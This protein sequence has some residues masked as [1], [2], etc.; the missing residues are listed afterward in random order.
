MKKARGFFKL[1]KLYEAMISAPA[2]RR[3][4]KKPARLAVECLEARETPTT[5]TWT[6]T[7]AG[8][9]DWNNAANWGGAGFPN[10]ADDVA[11]IN[12][13]IAAGTQIINLNVP[14]KVGTLNLGDSVVGTAGIINIA[15]N[16][17]SLTLDVGSGS[18]AINKTTGSASDAIN[19]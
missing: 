4:G 16:G 2:A 19:A 10:A 11:N 15:A 1:T 3:I 18:A 5:Y 7:A 13:D 6:P 9:F 14:I 17:G 12:N 8:T